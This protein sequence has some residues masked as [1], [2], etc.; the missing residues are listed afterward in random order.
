MIDGYAGSILRVDLSSGEVSKT[1][2]PEELIEKY[3]GGRGFV[4]KL[5]YDELPPNTDPYSPD[6]M[7]LAATGPLSGYFLPASGKIHFGTKSPATGGYADSN[8]G[9]HFGPALKYAGYDVLVLTGRAATPGYLFIDDEQVEIRPA[10][11]YWGMGALSCEA[12]LKKDLGEDFQILTIGPAGENR[13]R[14]ACISHDFGRQAGRTGVGAVLGSKNIKAIAVKGTGSLPVYDMEQAYAAGK[15]AYQKVFAKTGFKEWTPEGTAGI[16]DWTNAVG[17]FPTRNFQ[18]S[19]A[20][21]HKAINGKAILDQLKI[22]DKGCFC[23]PTPCGKYGHTKTDLGD[24]YVEG[25]EYET[26]ALFGGNCLLQTISEV[27]YANYVCDELGIDTISAGAVISWAIECVEKGILSQSQVGR[28]I[29][30]SDLGTVEFLLDQIARREGIGDLLAEGVMAASDKIGNGSEAFAIHVK[31]LEWTG[32]ETRNA[33]SMML[34]YMTADIGAHHNRAW[35]LGYDVTGAWTSVTDLISSGS[36]SEKM[37]KAQVKP[38]CAQ[39]VIDSQH[40]R[41][42]FDVLGICRLQYME[43]GFEEENYEKLF[44]LITGKKKSW[45]ELLTVSERI[46]NLT[47]V[48][49]NREIKNFGRHLDY[50]PARFYEEPI[51]SGPNEGYFLTKAD[52]DILLD[53]YY[54]AR[55]W[56]ENGIPTRETLKRLGLGELVKSHHN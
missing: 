46:W 38:E 1:P 30:F 40:T 31:G 17:V 8:M 56:D 12:Q 55:G 5:L 13:V 4:A 15:D 48:I 36:D 28:E 35:V 22:T 50:P 54:R 23:C 24:A 37:P 25:P 21:H 42:L 33:P 9:G 45:Q 47:R 10:D 6:N 44:H 32:Y 26:I 43:L 11:G 52:L 49:S 18:T 51:P 53:E 20:E 34:A 2:L 27:A 19:Y 41:P 14:F 16:T 39:Y 29:Q 7:F 3:I